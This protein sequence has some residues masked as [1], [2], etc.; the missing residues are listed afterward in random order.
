MLLRRI[1][2]HVREQNWFAV[3]IDFLIVVVGVFIGI[4]VANWNQARVDRIDE[5]MFLQQL[6]AELILSEEQ[7][8]NKAGARRHVVRNMESAL[9]VLFGRVERA[10]LSQD[11]CQAIG[12][13]RATNLVITELGSFNELAASGRVSIISDKHLRLSLV[14]LQQVI[15][16]SHR[17]KEHAT[18]IILNLPYLYPELMAVNGYFELAGATGRLEARA[19]VI[20]DTEG[21]KANQ[22]FLN[23]FSLNVDAYDGY[24]R[25]ALEPWIKA[26]EEVREQVD[27]VLDI[28]R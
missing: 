19:P 7:S 3:F 14:R 26:V 6:H 16:S 4:Q 18:K 27:D 1:T 28:N 5:L 23:A 24:I 12:L 21:M 22:S 8:K 11:E 9:D 15:R 25:D 17:N 20:C 13:T 2:K 10:T